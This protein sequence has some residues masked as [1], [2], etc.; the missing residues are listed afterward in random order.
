MGL[1][2]EMQHG[3]QGRDEPEGGQLPDS[4]A[5]A[6]VQGAAHHGLLEQGDRETRGERDECETREVRG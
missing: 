3:E 4:R 6:A 2:K 1:G 5:T